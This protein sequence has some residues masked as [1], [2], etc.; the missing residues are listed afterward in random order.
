MIPLPRPR[1][2]YLSSQRSGIYLYDKLAYECDSVTQD[3]LIFRRRFFY[4]E[5][6][7]CLFFCRTV[8]FIT[9]TDICIDVIVAFQSLITFV[10]RQLN[11]INLEVQDIETEFH[12][13]CHLC[14]L[15]GLLEGY[16]VPLHYFY[17]TPQVRLFV[18]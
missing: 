11:K 13:G 2:R 9:N 18:S 5:L 15:M 12:D 14:L 8:S 16:F 7:E 4:F 3:G 10:N 1:A 6:W 17:S